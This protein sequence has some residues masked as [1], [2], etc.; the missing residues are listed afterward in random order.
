MP[1]VK[2]RG[3]GPDDRGQSTAF[4]LSQV[5]GHAAQVFAGLVG[6]LDLTPPQAGLLR[7]IAH[8]PGR[9]QQALAAQLGTPPSRLVA[10]ADDLEGRGFIER[11]R[12][13]EDRRLYMLELGRAGRSMM[14]RLR[15]VAGTHD[16]VLLAALD[17]GEREQLH[18]LLERVVADQGLTQGVHPG[19]RSLGRPPEKGAA[20][21][22]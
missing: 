2:S 4:L 20:E 3:R 10:L 16:D 1:P 13:P 19:Y 22:E 7:A 6:E 14:D 15:T 11:R 18:T 17:P 9:S 5:G 8:S 12:N 21:P